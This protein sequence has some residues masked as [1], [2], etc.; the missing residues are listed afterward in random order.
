MSAMAF[1]RHV[2]LAETHWAD[3]AR[4]VCVAGVSS[5]GRG[6]VMAPAGRML[7][8]E[9]GARLNGTSRNNTGGHWR[10]T[11]GGVGRS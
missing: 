1:H 3:H 7:V 10:G 9:R 11:G 5:M 4:A 6:H 2:G 8:E